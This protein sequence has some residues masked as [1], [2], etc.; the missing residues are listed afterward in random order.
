[1]HTFEDISGF[2][3]PKTGLAG[4]VE[5]AGIILKKGF[6]Y[7]LNLY[8]RHNGNSPSKPFFDSKYFSHFPTVAE[9][10]AYASS[11]H[12]PLGTVVI[13]EGKS[14]KIFDDTHYGGAYADIE[15]SPRVRYA[16]RPELL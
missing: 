15:P 8:N 10:N 4:L 11:H 5:R 1:M 2:E 7:P 3:A 16:D 13:G 14:A 12:H 9:F 6:D